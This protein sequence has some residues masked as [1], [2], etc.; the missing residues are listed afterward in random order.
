MESTG[1]LQA[2]P[3]RAPLRGFGTVQQRHGLIEPHLRVVR[4]EF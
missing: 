2:R 4:C 3:E 1:R